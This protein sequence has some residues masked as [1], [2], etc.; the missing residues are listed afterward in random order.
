M[1]RMETLVSLLL[2]SS[3]SAFAVA[4]GR[5]SPPYG[6]AVR[7]RTTTIAR[8]QQQEPHE[9]YDD[10]ASS[11][12]NSTTTIWNDT[13]VSDLP[14]VL[15]EA[16]GPRPFRESEP[17]LSQHAF[18]SA[19]SFLSAAGDVISIKRH[20]GYANMMTGNMIRMA[21]ALVENRWRDSFKSL[22]LIACYILGAI[23]FRNVLNY[24]DQRK[25]LLASSSTPRYKTFSKTT[26]SPLL[27][28][29]V[30]LAILILGEVWSNMSLLAVAGGFINSATAHA[31]GGTIVFA[32]TGHMSKVLTGVLDYPQTREL[33]KGVIAS[34]K[35]VLWFFI[36]AIST[37]LLWNHGNSKPFF[38]MIGLVYAGVL[39]LVGLPKPA[40]LGEIMSFPALNGNSTIAPVMS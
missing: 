39:S 21:G 7:R 19:M 14:A 13:L 1:W 23:V 26:K 4:P 30:A 22:N 32:M 36:G 17:I 10:V 38:V 11:R 20:G 40:A 15:L 5:Y 34:A 6:G 8:L 24:H 12:S 16:A 3:S 2:I 37:T 27:V 25:L 31:S 9:P 28:A 33:N 29:P 35:I 18:L